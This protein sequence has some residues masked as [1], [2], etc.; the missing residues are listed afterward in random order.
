[1]S[2]HVQVM[3]D[4]SRSGGIPPISKNMSKNFK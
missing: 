3:D 1:M 2:T 4:A